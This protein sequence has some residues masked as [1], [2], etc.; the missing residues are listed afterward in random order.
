[1]RT[2]GR[3]EQWSPGSSNFFLN[4]Q[5]STAK[6]NFCL[7]GPNECVYPVRPLSEAQ[8]EAREVCHFP[9]VTHSTGTR[10]QE[11]GAGTTPSPAPSPPGERVEAGGR[12]VYTGHSQ[13]L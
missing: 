6:E 10:I 3:P 11:P 5:S 9:R 2:E 12:K 1:M 4:P 7:D 13:P 8:T